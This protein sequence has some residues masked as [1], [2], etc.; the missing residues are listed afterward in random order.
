[1][2]ILDTTIRDGS[3]AVDFRFSC[4]DVKEIVSKLDKLGFEFIE[5][6][7]GQGLNASSPEHG[8]AMHTDIEYMDACQSVIKNSKFGVFCIPGIARLKD[9]YIA[10]EHGV[11]FIRVGVNADQPKLAKEYIQEAKKLGLTVMTNFMKSYIVQAEQFAENSCIAE[12]YG[13]DYVY[14]VDSAGCMLPSDL[15]KYCEAIRKRTN[16]KLGFHGHNNLG[17]AVANSLYCAQE[18]FDLID[19]SLQGLGRSLGNAPTEM[20]VLALEKTGYHTGIDIPCLLEY[21]YVLLQDIS[22]KELQNPL[23]LV[24]G[25]AGFHSGFLRDIYKCCYELNVDPLRL[26]IEYSK[27]D[28][29][30]LNYKKLCEIAKGLPKDF[31]KHPYNFRKFFSS[32][33]KD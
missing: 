15:E 17:L 18:N 16:V 1:M 3:Y 12:E 33:Y 9:L 26:I 32:N 29:K 8:I 28:K 14:I 2:K 22:K 10:K 7:H 6:G 4:D 25:Y 11:S 24:C 21:G 30:T 23:D 20:F 27:Y 5:I 31:D 13:S 19:C